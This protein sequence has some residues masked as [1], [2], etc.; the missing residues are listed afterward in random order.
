MIKGPSCHYLRDLAIPI[1]TKLARRI[2]ARLASV[3]WCACRKLACSNQGTKTV[4]H[5][6]G[7]Q[8]YNSHCL[9]ARFNALRTSEQFVEGARMQEKHAM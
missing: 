1:T 6:K 8:H 9:V 3:R 5:S 7:I 2:E 4:G